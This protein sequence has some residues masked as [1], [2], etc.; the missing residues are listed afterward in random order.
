MILESKFSLSEYKLIINRFYVKCEAE[1]FMFVTKF[2]ILCS[3]VMYLTILR[4]NEH[5]WDKVAILSR[6]DYF[7][8]T[9]TILDQKSHFCDKFAILSQIG[10]L[11]DKIAILSR[12]DYY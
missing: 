10:L 6:N 7:W 12:I 4:Q 5:L 8:D 3:F 1:I 11:C 2:V 9:F